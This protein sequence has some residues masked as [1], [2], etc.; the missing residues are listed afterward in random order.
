MHFLLTVMMEREREHLDRAENQDQIVCQNSKVHFVCIAQ[1]FIHLYS[2]THLHDWVHVYLSILISSV[3]FM[4]LNAFG[5]Q[6]CMD[7]HVGFMR[8]GVR[9]WFKLVFAYL[10]AVYRTRL[11]FIIHVRS[12]C[13]VITSFIIRLRMVACWSVLYIFAYY[14]VNMYI[15]FL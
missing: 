13:F 4:S 5:S 15:A 9:Q 6:C 2:Y 8:P 11:C 1:L 10:F 14:Q 3:L 12:I 7:L